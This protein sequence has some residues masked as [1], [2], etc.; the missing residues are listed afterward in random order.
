MVGKCDVKK[1]DFWEVLF[2]KKIDIKP[3]TV[4]ITKDEN[5]CWLYEKNGIPDENKIP[6]VKQHCHLT[7]S[8]RRLAHDKCNLS[9]RNNFVSFL[10]IFFHNSPGPDCFLFFEKN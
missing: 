9:T 1:R 5:I 7:G 4:P 3:N 6:V 10:P 2:G 8:F